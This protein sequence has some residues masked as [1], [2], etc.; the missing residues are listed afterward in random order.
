MPA[1]TDPLAD[2]K[3]EVQAEMAAEAA[4]AA[5]AAGDVGAEDSGAAEDEAAA[6]AAAA[7]AAA[8]GAEEQSGAEPAEAA[9]D[10][11]DAERPR[12][13]RQATVPRERY[14][15][16]QAKLRK[17]REARGALQAEL[18]ALKKP[19]DGEGEKPRAK[20]EDEIRA[21]AKAQARLEIKLE[22]FVES[23]NKTY[24]R[25]AFE[26]AC[27]ELVSHGA[28][29]NI[30][31]VALGA[32][33]TT[34]DAAKAIY[35][36]AQKE[37]AE[38]ERFLALSTLRQA[39][40]L[41]KLAESRPSRSARATEAEGEDEEEAPATRGAKPARRVSEAPAPITPVRGNGR[42]EEGFGDGVPDDVFTERFNKR[43]E[44]KVGRR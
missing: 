42:I 19:K 28:N 9:K 12:R 40:T 41:A 20:T 22:N 36:L 26:D 18:D 27:N 44:A 15:E 35:L 24:T 31:T 29:G 6:A 7:E 4:A 21:E 5:E 11:D 23:G 17:E 2:I 16:T 32:T 33:E 13:Q 8:E 38:I 39:A 30:V 3:S 25:E 14:D 43:Q 10:G 34:A 37:P 1:L